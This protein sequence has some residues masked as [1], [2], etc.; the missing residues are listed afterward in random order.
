M[1]RAYLLIYDH[2]VGTREE[3]REFLDEQP[4]ILH[5]RHD[6]P[7]T[8]YL[9][10]DQSAKGLYEIFQNFNREHGGFLISEVGSNRQGWLPRKTWTFLNGERYTKKDK[11]RPYFST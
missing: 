9:I 10:S 11:N 6:L 7:N 2:E 1:T 4:E 3:V 5:W 8:F